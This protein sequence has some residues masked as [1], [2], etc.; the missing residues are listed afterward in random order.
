VSVGRIEH[1]NIDERERRAHEELA[2]ATRALGEQAIED[3]PLFRERLGHI[4]RDRLLVL[5]EPREVR[6]LIERV[7]PL[8]ELLR[9]HVAHGPLRLV[10]PI[11][12]VLAREVPDNRHAL[13]ICVSRSPSRSIRTGICPNVS[14]GLSEGHRSIV[15]GGVRV[16]PADVREEEPRGLRPSADGKI[17]KLEGLRGRHSWIVPLVACLFNAPASIDQDRLPGSAE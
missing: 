13:R 6:D 14:V 16:L 2:P 5:G 15:M 12:V 8:D 1:Q 17:E 3:R 4:L 10:G 9:H 7:P 11:E